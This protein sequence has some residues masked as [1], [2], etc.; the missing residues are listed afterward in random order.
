MM[1]HGVANVKK[2]VDWTCK[3]QERDKKC[4][5]KFGQGAW[6]AGRFERCSYLNR[7]SDKHRVILLLYDALPREIF[8]Q[9]EEFL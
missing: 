5:H 7:R 8:R 6:K 9:K 3:K 4:L 1:M 2:S